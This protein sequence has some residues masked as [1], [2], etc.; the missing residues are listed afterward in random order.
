MEEDVKTVRRLSC[1]STRE[2]VRERQREALTLHGSHPQT[3]RCMLRCIEDEQNIDT[4]L[5]MP[6]YRRRTLKREEQ[7]RD[8]K[9]LRKKGHARISAGTC[10]YSL[11]RRPSRR[12]GASECP[13]LC[14]C[15]WWSCALSGQKGEEDED[16]K[17][18]S[19]EQ[20]L[21][22]RGLPNEK[23][24]LKTI[25]SAGEIFTRSGQH[26][27]TM[28]FEP[29]RRSGADMQ[30]R[31]HGDRHSQIRIYRCVYTCT[32]DHVCFW[33]PTDEGASPRASLPWAVL[34]THLSVL[35]AA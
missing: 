15:C 34:F 4:I 11:S 6:H 8:G 18:E 30:I 28:G 12:L 3:L 14:C 13:R 25:Q 21:G 35:I 16:G 24:L 19:G 10:R 29:Q 5:H 2:R 20:D 33:A 17:E 1:K 9:S 22:D 27:R 31:V 23:R 26:V 32:Q 7:T